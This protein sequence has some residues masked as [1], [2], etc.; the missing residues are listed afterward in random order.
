MSKENSREDLSAKTM[1]V[2]AVIFL[3]LTVFSIKKLSYW[4][5][6]VVREV[7]LYDTWSQMYGSKHS[8]RERWIGDFLDVKS[9]YR[10]EYEVSGGLHQR[11]LKDKS[12]YTMDLAITPEYF[13]SR[14]DNHHDF[15]V[16][17]SAVVNSIAIV[18]AGSA[19]YL[20]C[21]ERRRRKAQE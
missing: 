6:S 13:V 14:A 12:P 17:F 20:F 8:T 10:F 2:I 3:A 11:M 18:T 15:W 19:V 21:Q 1:T 9:G 4:K 5:E 7:V 16:I